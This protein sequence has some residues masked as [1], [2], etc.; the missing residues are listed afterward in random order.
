MGV[1]GVCLFLFRDIVDRGKTSLVDDEESV[2]D[3]SQ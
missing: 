3:E 1:I 2:G